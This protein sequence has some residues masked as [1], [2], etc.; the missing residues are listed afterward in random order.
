MI[1]PEDR[2]AGLPM[3]ALLRISELGGGIPE[4]IAGKATGSLTA[5]FQRLGWKL[6]PIPRFWAPREL[7]NGPNGSG[8]RAF[9]DFHHSYEWLIVPPE[10]SPI[11][12]RKVSGK[13]C[14]IRE[15][16]RLAM[17][18]EAEPAAPDAGGS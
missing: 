18:G 14:A 6:L 16:Y 2:E 7:T 12:A 5:Q 8:N 9:I 15:T 17:F 10:D 13:V 1:M 11:R 4:P 3:T